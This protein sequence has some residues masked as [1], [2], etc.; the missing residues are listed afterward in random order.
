M[1]DIHV[2]NITNMHTRT[3]MENE[4][5]YERYRENFVCFRL[6]DG[7]PNFGKLRTFLK[8]DFQRVIIVVHMD[9]IIK[10]VGGEQ[11]R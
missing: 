4:G 2:P 8:C 1:F 10:N 5:V 3:P 6:R 11:N 7:L 9:K